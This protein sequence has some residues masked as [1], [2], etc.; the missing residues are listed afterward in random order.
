[1]MTMDQILE[2]ERQCREDDRRVREQMRRYEAESA[3]IQLAIDHAVLQYQIAFE[4][5][6]ALALNPAYQ[7]KVTL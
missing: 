3:K 4:S 6:W 1:M 7:V 2:L 5:M